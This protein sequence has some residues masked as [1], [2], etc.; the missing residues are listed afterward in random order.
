M[1][2]LWAKDRVL[3]WFYNRHKKDKNYFQF[4]LIANLNYTKL[5]QVKKQI[6]EKKGQ[7]FTLVF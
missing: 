6:C 4:N 7:K 2:D 1:I 5:F 3:L